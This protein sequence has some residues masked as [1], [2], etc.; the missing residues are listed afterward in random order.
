MIFSNSPAIFHPVRTIDRST[1]GT[2]PGQQ[3]LRKPKRVST[4]R[5]VLDPAILAK[6]RHSVRV[7]ILTCFVGAFSQLSNA[8]EP[9]DATER[10]LQR[11]GSIGG[12]VADSARNHSVN[13]YWIEAPEGLIVI[14]TQWRLS[15]ARRAVDDLRRSTDSVVQAILIT[16][17]H[18]DHFGGLPVFYQASNRQ[19]RLIASRPTLRAMLHDEQGFRANRVDDFGDDFPV[20]LPEGFERID[21]DDET[22]LIAGTEL[23]AVTYRGNEAPASTVYYLPS[24]RA[25]FTG[26][27]VNGAT[28][29]VLYQG[30]L[31]GWITQLDL[32]AR[33]FPDAQTI[34]PGHGEP[35]PAAQMIAA[36][37]AYLIQ[38]RNLVETALLDDG[39][40]DLQDRRTIRMALT[41]N[42]PKWRTSAGFANRHALIEQ[43]IRWVLQGWRVRNA[44]QGNPAEFR[45]IAE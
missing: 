16:H 32:L 24:E 45:E 41:D 18:S 43:N 17:P 23:E 35:G 33:R 6:A 19:A 12:Y 28:T 8:D 25:L 13:S 38:L 27:L 7:A 21:T 26:D 42:F 40:V 15:D 20:S 22:L 9:L 2:P 36:E 3:Y 31:D 4:G 1:P 30:D 44:G 5:W 14:D 34:Y 29:P 37:K 39:Q 10:S 11:A